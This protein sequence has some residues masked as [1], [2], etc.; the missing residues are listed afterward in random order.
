MPYNATILPSTFRRRIT[1]KAPITLTDS[2][3]GI[4]T[5][6]YTDLYTT[7]A[8]VNEISTNRLAYYGMDIFTTAWEIKLRYIATRT[9]STGTVI[10][11]GDKLLIVNDPKVIEQDYKRFIVLIC[12]EANTQ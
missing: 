1:V 3:G 9:I 8:S 10:G 12:T 4:G 7:W 2:A 5:T 6:G 11:Y